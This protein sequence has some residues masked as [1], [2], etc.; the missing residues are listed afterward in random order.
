MQNAEA[1]TTVVA[2]LKDDLDACED[3]DHVHDFR[4]IP[5][6]YDE[7]EVQYIWWWIETFVTDIQHQRRLGAIARAPGQFFADLAKLHKAQ[8]GKPVYIP[9]RMII[10]L[11]RRLLQAAYPSLDE[12]MLEAKVAPASRAAKNLLKLTGI[13]KW[14]MRS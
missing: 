4:T 7:I 14:R 6:M 12:I 5:E 3:R 9:R 10:E 2:V 13:E 1:M 8:T 11:E